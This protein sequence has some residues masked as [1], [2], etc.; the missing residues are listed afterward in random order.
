LHG[1]QKKCKQ[2]FYRRDDHVGDLIIHGGRDHTVMNVKENGASVDWFQLA[3]ITI[4]VN[5]RG[6]NT[7]LCL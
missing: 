5:M 3:K 7:F 1:G 6:N 4:L 2:S